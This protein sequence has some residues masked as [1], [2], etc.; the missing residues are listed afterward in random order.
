MEDLISI[1]F[2]VKNEGNNV[3]NTLNS[4]IS[5]KTNRSYE[6]IIV[7][8]NSEDGC[9]DFLKDFKST[10]PIKYIKANGIGSSQARNVGAEATKG[11]YLIFCDAHLFF[12]DY[13]LD[14]MI[15]P[16]ENNLTNAVTPIISPHDNPKVKGYGQTLNMTNFRAKWNGVRTE[17][18]DTAIL[19]GGCF[20]ISREIFFAVGGFEKRFRVW[21]FEDIEFSI[22]MWL[23]GYKCSVEP[24]VQ[25]LHIF[26][27]VFPYQMN[28]NFSD[29]NMIRLAYSHFSEERIEKCKKFVR[30]QQLTNQFVEDNIKDSV[31]EQRALYFSKRKYDDDW[32]LNKFNIEF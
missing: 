17:L 8:D 31:L 16:L 21:G 30:S 25:I 2:P 26:R 12:E 28:A 4:L 3:L 9:C 5:T 22:R 15:K 7:D 18:S 10:V 11:K 27:K 6:V 1:I 14:K 32:F 29:Y 13:W 23:F 24:S 20:A 19:S